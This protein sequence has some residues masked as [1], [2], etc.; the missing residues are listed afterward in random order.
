M[1]LALDDSGVLTFMGQTVRRDPPSNMAS[2]R[3]VVRII[4]GQPNTQLGKTV[5]RLCEAFPEMMSRCHQLRINGKGKE[6]PVADAATL[7]EIILVCPGKTAKV[8]C[9]AFLPC[10]S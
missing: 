9:L 3:D 1:Q 7:L 10:M 2:V 6:T 4:T 8:R 5:E